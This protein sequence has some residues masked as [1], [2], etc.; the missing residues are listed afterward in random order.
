MADKKLKEDL[1]YR[2]ARAKDELS[3][4]EARK[5][6]SEEK[7]AVV[8]KEVQDRAD[9][10]AELTAKAEATKL[11]LQA[12][13][14]EEVRLREKEYLPFE[15][16]AARVNPVEA[17]LATKKKLQE[18]ENI[19]DKSSIHKELPVHVDVHFNASV[20]SFGLSR[21]TTFE[22]LKEEA[23]FHWKVD[24]RS[25]VLKNAND[26]KW[27]GSDLVQVA[28]A[29]AYHKTGIAP[30]VRL[31]MVIDSSQS[32]NKGKDGDSN[33]AKRKRKR[34]KA[35][36][37][38][39][40]SEDT[41]TQEERLP[42]SSSGDELKRTR[43]M[44]RQMEKQAWEAAVMQLS[45]FFHDSEYVAKVDPNLESNIPFNRQ[46]YFRLRLARSCVWVLFWMATVGLS[47]AAMIF[48][49]NTASAYSSV[50]EVYD[51]LG[52]QQFCVPISEITNSNGTNSSSAFVSSCSAE[53]G[54]IRQFGGISSNS[55]D[56]L[57]AV[58]ASHRI[59][60]L[61]ELSFWIRDVLMPSL[62]LRNSTSGPGFTSAPSLVS[63]QKVLLGGVSVN[64]AQV[65]PGACNGFFYQ[66]AD[67]ATCPCYREYDPALIDKT[68]CNQAPFAFS[69]YT[70]IGDFTG[71]MRPSYVGD[72]CFALM[73]PSS[74]ISSLPWANDATRVLVFQFN[75]LNL[76]LAW[77]TEV[78]LG[79]EVG[80][81][82][83]VV[84]SIQVRVLPLSVYSAYSPGYEPLLIVSD[85][86]LFVYSLAAVWFW[87]VRPRIL[88]ISLS[89]I[90]PLRTVWNLIA[91]LLFLVSTVQ[92]GLGIGYELSIVKS[93]DLNPASFQNLASQMQAFYA[94]LGL[95]TVAL[96][97]LIL[98]IFKHLQANFKVSKLFQ[99]IHRSA[100]PLGALILFLVLALA[101]MGLWA[102][103]AWGSYLIEWTR[104]ESCVALLAGMVFGAPINFVELRETQNTLLW[105][106]FFF[107][108]WVGFVILIL[109]Q[110]FGAVVLDAFLEIEAVSL[111]RQATEEE[112]YWSRLI[113]SPLAWF[114]RGSPM[115]KKAQKAGSSS[116]S[117]SG[118]FMGWLKK[119][120]RRLM[121]RFRK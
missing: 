60:E 19:L 105:I 8:K 30:L 62:G 112:L 58:P 88:G 50:M 89:L 22:S 61:S 43:D 51:A 46:R 52:Y 55:G 20:C 37:Q 86:F 56:Y 74:N 104:I 115:D 21:S 99:T 97:L 53:T 28:L 36:G 45:P 15:E 49:F 107:L 110:L 100:R 10:L 116:S 13:K 4:R 106:V 91:V 47:I 98:S 3:T 80:P 73:D 78:K 118:G 121:R 18:L 23:C 90:Q 31:H 7:A 39:A 102:N 82:Q 95:S 81:T 1:R 66:N 67:V 44:I 33:D 12:L 84:T 119:P 2:I 42:P 9:A 64:Y 63:P 16:A 83:L 38:I 114:E 48:R 11:R 65:I 72:A 35:P 92:I 96:F 27:K 5:R 54:F 34:S 108:I 70:I 117:S 69:A 68:A 17:L 76:N 109:M 24:A 57:E 25:T 93:I 79:V 103:L 113:R 101:S 111:D 85:V 29:E 75:L 94:Y 40:F 41:L 120:W 26:G 14:G 71:V 59:L 87:I 32:N 77:I 6:K